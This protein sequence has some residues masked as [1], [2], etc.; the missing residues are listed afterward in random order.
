MS[1]KFQYLKIITNN[2][3]FS[4]YLAYLKE[5]GHICYDQPIIFNSAYVAP[6]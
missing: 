3:L 6:K 4:Q 5:V 2:L 1:I